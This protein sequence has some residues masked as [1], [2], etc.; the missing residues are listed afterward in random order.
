MRTR[1]RVASG[2]PTPFVL[3]S[4]QRSGTSW[5]MDRLT[6]HPGVGGY[7]EVLLPGVT[8]RPNWPAGAA[9]RPFLAGYVNER[10]AGPPP[11][12][13]HCYLFGYLDHLYEPRRDL[14][15]IGFKL[16]YSHVLRY[17]EILIYLRVRGVRVI[18]LIRGNLLDIFLSRE[19]MAK[20][21][22]VHAW[23]DRQRTEV[24]L[25]LDTTALVAQLRRLDREQRIA[26]ALLRG[27]GL[28]TQEV[29]YETLLGDDAPLYGTL[30][31]LGIQD[32]AVTELC[33]ELLKLARAP[34]RESIT[35][36]D[37]VQACLRGTKY[38]RFLADAV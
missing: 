15:A 34:H 23:S 38:E 24:Q 21:R 14:R 35:N 33:S 25:E 32:T 26:R 37:E 28:Q 30:S 19:A 31:F 11:G 8:G 12:L 29:V 3:L 5:F 36:Y 20:R 10:R 13:S 9:D 22:T 4:T 18:H 27:L 1:R 17:P 16:M 2:A 6:K 7:G